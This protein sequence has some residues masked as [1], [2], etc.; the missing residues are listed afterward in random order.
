LTELS[1][2]VSP[3]SPLGARRDEIADRRAMLARRLDDGYQRIDAA[4]ADGQEMAR[5]EDFWLDLLREYEAL[6]GPMEPAA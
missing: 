3:K 2:A 4:I 6:F 1:A 5:W